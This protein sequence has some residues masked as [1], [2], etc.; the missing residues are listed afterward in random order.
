MRPVRRR[1][2]TTTIPN[3]IHTGLK[4]TTQIR[5]LPKACPTPDSERTA[6]LPVS[7]GLHPA[8][9][10]PGDSETNMLM[11]LV[12]SALPASLSPLIVRVAVKA[13]GR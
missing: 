1:T 11:L 10:Q 13:K 12:A 2:A 9:T 8:T 4:I 3:T 6:V 7:P 5:K